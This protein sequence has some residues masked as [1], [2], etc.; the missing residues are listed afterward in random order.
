MRKGDPRG[1]WERLALAASRCAIG[2][3]LVPL[4]LLF[5]ASS[6]LPICQRARP[7]AEPVLCARHPP[8]MGKLP[9]ARGR[10]KC[11]MAPRPDSR[12]TR[13]GSSW[14]RSC[15]AFCCLAPV[16]PEH[17]AGA[18]ASADLSLLLVMV[19]CHRSFDR[20]ETRS[21]PQGSTELVFLPIFLCKPPACHV[22]D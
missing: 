17:G 20:M 2:P 10:A 18:N 8:L 14:K 6:R 21:V 1:R 11:S 16:Y 12:D 22:I 5:P 15:W 4:F 3:R 13:L 9:K 19:S 7:C